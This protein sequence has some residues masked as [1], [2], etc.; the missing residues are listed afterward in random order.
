MI[1]IKYERKLV[2]ISNI[3]GAIRQVKVNLKIV[4]KHT[5]IMIKI[6]TFYTFLFVKLKKFQLFTP[7]LHHINAYLYRIHMNMC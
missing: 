4:V 2:S 6:Y 5:W 7:P 1:R 3:R